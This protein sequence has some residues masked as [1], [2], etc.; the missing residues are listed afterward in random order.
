MGGQGFNSVTGK[1]IRVLKELRNEGTASALQMAIPLRGLGDHIKV[2]DG[3]ISK[4]R[5]K[6]NVLNKY[7]CAYHIDTPIKCLLFFVW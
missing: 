6:H 1:I 2:S 3:L 7:L 5:H 4:R